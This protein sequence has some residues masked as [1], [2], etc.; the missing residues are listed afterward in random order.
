MGKHNLLYGVVVIVRKQGRVLGHVINT[1]ARSNR[2]LKSKNTWI[3]TVLRLLK[4]NGR[5]WR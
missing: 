4:E 2:G 5:N 3:S 1:T